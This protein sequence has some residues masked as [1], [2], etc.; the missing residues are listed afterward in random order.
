MGIGDA[1]DADSY[2]DVDRTRLAI[3]LKLSAD[4]ICQ[5]WHHSVWVISASSKGYPKLKSLTGAYGRLTEVSRAKIQRQDIGNYRAYRSRTRFFYSQK[6]FLLTSFSAF[7]KPIERGTIGNYAASGTAIIDQLGAEHL[8]TGKLLYT[9]RVIA[10][11]KIAAHDEIIPLK[12]LYEICEIAREMLNGDPAVGRVIARPFV[13]NAGSFKRTEH[14][15]DFSL[16]AA[17]RNYSGQSEEGGFDERGRGKDR[18]H[19]C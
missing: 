7:E 2:G 6:D 19:L 8:A 4:S 9:L 17:A 1:P 15:K 3:S 16:R 12:Q 5:T 18:R 11:F 14:R 10:S 13:G